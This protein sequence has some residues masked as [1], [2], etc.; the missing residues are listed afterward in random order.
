MEFVHCK[1]HRRKCNVQLD[2]KEWFEWFIRLVHCWVVSNF[3]ETFWLIQIVENSWEF[4]KGKVRKGKHFHFTRLWSTLYNFSHLS[5]FNYFIQIH[6]FEFKITKCINLVKRSFC[7]L[8]VSEPEVTSPGI[9]RKILFFLFHRWNRFHG[10]KGSFTD[11]KVCNL[12]RR[13]WRQSHVSYISFNFMNQTIF[14]MFH[15]GTVEIFYCENCTF[16]FP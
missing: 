11:G 1:Y 7:I 3:L 8:V 13:Q 5:H 15:L 16:S 14:L 9:P 4:W 2:H 6:F 12:S 10:L